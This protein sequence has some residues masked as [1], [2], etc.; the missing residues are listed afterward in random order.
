M[1]AYLN[2]AKDLSIGRVDATVGY[3]YNDFKTTNYNYTDNTTDGSVSSS[4]VYSYDAPR[5]LIIS[6]FGS[7][8]YS[9]K[10]KYL[11]TASAR[12]DGASKFSKANR[13]GVFPS[14]AVGWRIKEESFL[15]NVNSN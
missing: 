11:L 6:V 10:G 12:K 15:K 9:Y 13:W 8:K 5:N 3:A 4:P 7:L 2:Y 1:D 14:A